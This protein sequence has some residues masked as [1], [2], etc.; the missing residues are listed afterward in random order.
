[1]VSTQEVL[2]VDRQDDES[3]RSE[4]TMRLR[5]GLI[6][7]AAALTAACQ[8]PVV[9]VAPLPP[10]EYERLG[11]AEAEACGDLYLILPWHQFLAR[12]L[13]ERVER[14]YEGAVASVPGATGLVNVTLQERWYWWG[15]AS[16]RCTKISGDAIRSVGRN[17]GP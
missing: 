16:A 3:I 17:R 14:A 9:N 13:N 10:A 4:P 15:L 7:A 8:S 2:A 1:M 5:R 11:G 12:G 6:A